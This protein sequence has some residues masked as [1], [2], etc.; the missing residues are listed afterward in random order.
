MPHLEIYLQICGAGRKSQKSPTLVVGKKPNG[1]SRITLKTMNRK[2]LEALEEEINREVC[3]MA[4]SETPKRRPLT[5][6]VVDIDRYLASSPRMLWILKEPWDP[7][8][9]GDK[10]GGWSLTREL[11]PELISEGKIGSSPTYR[12]MAYVT[13][14]VRNNFRSYSDIPYASEDPRVGESLKSIAY[15]NVNKCPGTPRSDPASIAASFHRN[16]D[17]LG[18]QVAIINPE[19]IIAGN[20]LH[21]FY[22]DFDLHSEDLKCASSVGFCRRDG[23][24]YVNA[25]HPAYW[26]CAEERYVNDLVAAIRN[27]LRAV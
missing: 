26:G 19:V 7:Y 8:A 2:Q 14:P 23:R 3:R 10:A 15:I 20:I 9:E 21:L 12:K 13:F 27:H 5:D 17:I 11:I 6:G 25:Y 1:K 22:E 16:R 18:R 4:A 24:L